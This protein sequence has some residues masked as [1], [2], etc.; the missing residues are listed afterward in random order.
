MSGPHILNGIFFC[1]I[2]YTWSRRGAPL[3]GALVTRYVFGIR[4]SLSI[5]WS[6]VGRWWRVQNRRL[7]KQLE[8]LKGQGTALERS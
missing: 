6:P 3:N 2:A 7:I 5:A 8:S 1:G 4:R